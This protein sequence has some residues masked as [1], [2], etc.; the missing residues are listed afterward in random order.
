MRGLG[1][2]RDGGSGG[3][4]YLVVTPGNDGDLTDLIEPAIHS[5][6]SGIPTW[7]I[8]GLGA[9]GTIGTLLLLL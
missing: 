6:E 3:D 9:L 8:W 4:L 2:A 7:V 5:A 1:E